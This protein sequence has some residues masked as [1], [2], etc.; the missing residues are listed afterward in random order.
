MHEQELNVEYS[1]RMKALVKVKK[2]Y[3]C[4]YN[5]LIFRIQIEAYTCDRLDWL[6]YH[7][8]LF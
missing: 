3:H 5:V 7:R 8:M 6:S 4:L 2:S 1:R